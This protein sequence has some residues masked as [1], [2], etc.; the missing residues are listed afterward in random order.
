MT[1]TTRI[2]SNFTSMETNRDKLKKL[3]TKKSD[4]KAKAA[5]RRKNR[6]W[7]R[8]SARIAFGVLE[9][10]E[11]QG[12][13]QSELAKRMGVSK[14]QVSKIVKGQQNLTLETID[15]LEQVL[16]VEL[17]SFPPTVIEAKPAQQLINYRAGVHVE[18][19][20]G[21]KAKAVGHQKVSL[22]PDTMVAIFSNQHAESA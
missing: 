6:G 19:N 20:Y 4:S 2:N 21:I 14:Q 7:L 5:E 17:M 16:G 13:S 22:Q 10:L 8:K 18:P 12:M 3:V 1:L 11:A 15:R 9:A